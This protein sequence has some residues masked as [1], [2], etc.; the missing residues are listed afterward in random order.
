MPDNLPQSD[1]VP[2]QSDAASARYLRYA[3]PYLKKPG[4]R[5]PWAFFAIIITA[6]LL[7]LCN[8]YFQGKRDSGISYFALPGS[9]SAFLSREG[10]EVPLTH[11]TVLRAG[12]EVFTCDNLL[13]VLLFSGASNMR[14]GS[15]TQLVLRAGRKGEGLLNKTLCLQSGRCW[16]QAKGE[17]GIEIVIPGGIAD[18]RSGVVD[19]SVTENGSQTISVWSG[20]VSFHPDNGTRGKVIVIRKGKGLTLTS[21]GSI[22]GHSAISD[23]WKRLNKNLTL[24]DILTRDLSQEFADSEEASSPSER[25]FLP[26]S[27]P[28][29]TEINPVKS[30]DISANTPGSIRHT[31]PPLP[32][33][34]GTYPGSSPTGAPAVAAESR[35]SS[36]ARTSAARPSKD[37]SGKWGPLGLGGKFVYEFPQGMTEHGRDKIPPDTKM[38]MAYMVEEITIESE[39]NLKWRFQKVADNLKQKYNMHLNRKYTLILVAKGD[40]E[41]MDKNY[42]AFAQ[43]PPTG[44]LLYFRI[45]INDDYVDYCIAHEFAHAWFDE[46]HHFNTDHETISTI[47]EGFALWIQM[48]YALFNHNAPQAALAVRGIASNEEWAADPERWNIYCRGIRGTLEIEESYGERG[49]FKYITT[50]VDP[51]NARQE[52]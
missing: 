20:E 17:C 12:D 21:N 5:P 45:N 10:R 52:R 3:A 11:T 18:I 43:Y 37:P 32:G 19:F 14:L 31:P 1:S 22:A 49:V 50:G 30:R 15:E 44:H 7:W 39:N 38:G 4:R 28:T 23:K 24:N 29:L 13:T 42:P 2:L 36:T 34:R 40:F 51:R 47:N 46:H 48:K 6:A 41:T 35:R 16:V 27:T 33:A 26:E 9:S 25:T 8:V